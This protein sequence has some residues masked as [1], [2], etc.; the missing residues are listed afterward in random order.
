MTRQR[1]GGGMSRFHIVSPW[2]SVSQ[3]P[4]SLQP[5]HTSR[6]ERGAPLSSLGNGMMFLKVGVANL[7]NEKASDYLVPG[8]NGSRGN[9]R[10][11]FP[12]FTQLLP[13]FTLFTNPWHFL[14]FSGTKKGQLIPTVP[15]EALS[16]SPAALTWTPIWHLI[17]LVQSG[18][19]QRDKHQTSHTWVLPYYGVG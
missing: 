16:L 11:L 13:Y 6:W 9:I 15:T 5:S 18:S 19:G 17:T 1:V 12:S 2:V 8:T 10:S 14:E 7:G 3:I 4:H